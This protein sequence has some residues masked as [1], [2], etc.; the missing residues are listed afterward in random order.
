MA[1]NLIKM[2]TRPKMVTALMETFGFGLTLASIVAALMMV[3]AA[4][5]V[6]WIFRALPP[7]TL[8][9][10][11]GP[12]GSSFRRIAEQYQK[13]LA[14]RGVTLR[15][16]TSQGSLENLQ[17]LKSSD[18]GVDVGF[19]QSGQVGDTSPSNLISLG[20][21]SY[22]PLLVFYRSTTKLVHLSDLAGKRLAVGAEGSGSRALALTLLQANDIV[23]GGATTFLDLDADAAASALIDGKV[24]A[25][26]LMGDSAPAA[27]MRKLLRA[28]GVNLFSFKQAD[29]YVRRFAYLNKVELPEG[30]IDLA[31]NLPAEDIELVAPTV[32]LVARQGLHPALSDL[33]LE[34]A[35]DIHG[36]ATI[37][38]KRGEFPAPLVQ[39]I[40]ISRDAARFYKSGVGYLEQMG[41]PFWLSSLL[42]RVLVVFVPV[43]LVLIPTVRFFPT[44]YRLTNRLKIF[45]CYRPLLQ[46]ERQA[47]GDPTPEQRTAMLKRLDEIE[48]MVNRLRMPASFA[49]QFYELR[50]HIA[51]VRRRI[52][53]EKA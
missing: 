44:V 42:E 26:F 51:F 41:G 17:R 1:L 52:C 40:K 27:T 11:T 39:D 16:V 46:L 7:H 20:S 38:Q 10:T 15:I 5:A 53:P 12:E 37:L 29:A 28:D 35:K 43:L 48:E 9:M 2:K 34:A 49:D 23:P 4:L 32:Q 21:I 50:G 25:V 33:L 6:F 18:S 3:V 24:D 47:L 30:A 45:R 19:V 31:K 36:R 14:D 22:Q 13:K 8:V